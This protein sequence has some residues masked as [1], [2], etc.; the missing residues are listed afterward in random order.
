MF[1][2]LRNLSN[3]TNKS[4]LLPRKLKSLSKS[5][6]EVFLRKISVRISSDLNSEP[7]LSQQQISEMH[8]M[9]LKLLQYQLQHQN[10][11]PNK[12]LS[13]RQHNRHQ[14]LSQL[15]L[16]PFCGVFL[17]QIMEPALLIPNQDVQVSN[18]QTL[19]ANLL[20][21][22]TLHWYQLKQSSQLNQLKSTMNLPKKNS[23]PKPETLLI[24]EN[25]ILKLLRNQNLLLN[26]SKNHPQNRKL[27]L[28]LKKK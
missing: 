15:K 10:Q 6:P 20:L 24:Q 27:L 13:T 23:L 18:D 25:L 17:D 26:Q 16:T 12:N 21:S 1:L 2:N 11:Q 7:D 4:H 3:L 9:Y 28:K 14:F 8:H 19:F 22:L 5:Q